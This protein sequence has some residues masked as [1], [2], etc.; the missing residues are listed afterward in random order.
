MA[1]GILCQACGIEAPTKKYVFLQNIGALVIR[2]HKQINCNLCK[3]CAHK[4]F[5]QFTGTTLVLGPWGTISLIAAPC[6]II[7][8]IVRYFAI[9]GHAPVPPDARIPVLDQEAIN[10]LGPVTDELIGRLNQKE[11]MADVARDLARRTGVTPGQIV[12]YVIALSQR[13]AS[14]PPQ[15]RT[16]GFPVQPV[17]AEPL[18][19]LIEDSPLAPLP[20]TV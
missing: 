13:P 10:K 12:K 14:P 1:S 2:Y 19:E 4:Y 20:P 9:F 16:Y 6:F 17:K 8:N 7:N 15:A 18:P 3:R 5:W 11:A